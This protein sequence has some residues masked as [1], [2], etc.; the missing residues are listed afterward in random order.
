MSNE[1][2]NARI[3][4]LSNNSEKN[5][6][7]SWSET[8]S[9]FRGHILEVYPHPDE[10]VEGFLDLLEGELKNKGFSVHPTGAMVLI[11]EDIILNM[12]DDERIKEIDPMSEH[13]DWQYTSRYCGDDSNE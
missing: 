4:V 6:I 13:D 11:R 8:R 9:I 2:N 10:M 1:L 5:R 12:I 7:S 3:F